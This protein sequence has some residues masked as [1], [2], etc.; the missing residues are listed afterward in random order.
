MRT[1]VLLAGLCVM[2]ILIGADLALA[3]NPTGYGQAGGEFDIRVKRVPRSELAT[4]KKM[5]PPFEATQKIL[6]EGKE[7]F[8]GRGGCISCH[9]QREKVMAEPQAI[10]PFN[11]GIS[12]IPNSKNTAH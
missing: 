4:A 6:A 12:P 10:F 7:I 9:G 3:V 11:H 5:K 8:L 2:T 1:V